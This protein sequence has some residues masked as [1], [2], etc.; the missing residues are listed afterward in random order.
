[1]L[2]FFCL[3]ARHNID[4]P[5]PEFCIFHNILDF[6][7]HS[8]IH[9][10][11]QSAIWSWFYANK[12]RRNALWFRGTIKLSLTRFLLWNAS[13]ISEKLVRHDFD[14]WLHHHHYYR[15]YVLTI[16][17][18]RQERN[19]CNYSLHTI[20]RWNCHGFGFYLLL[21]SSQ[22]KLHSKPKFNRIADEPE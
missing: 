6:P 1:M 18:Q 8:E 19:D 15:K 17:L 16:T 4:P 9:C 22:C 3:F 2:L 13:L 11:C 12:I 21:M 20:P 10:I 5:R 7:N 14:R